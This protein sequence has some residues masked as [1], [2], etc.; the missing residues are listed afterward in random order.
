MEREKLSKLQEHK[1][2][3]ANKTQLS[4]FSHETCPNDKP[5]RVLKRL[6]NVVMFSWIPLLN[7]QH[8][9][10]I[11][12]PDNFLNIPHRSQQHAQ[13]FLSSPDNMPPLLL[14]HPVHHF[15]KSFY[16]SCFS[17]VVHLR[18]MNWNGAVCHVQIRSSLCMALCNLGFCQRHWNTVFTVRTKAIVCH[19]N[20]VLV[21]TIIAPF[22]PS[23]HTKIAL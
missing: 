17:V 3:W 9:T 13:L 19:I 6:H 18:M 15:K 10:S 14:H 16:V 12:I 8:I 5:S 22:W 2:W 4:L 23:F 1:V 20:R 11:G 21:V 7:R